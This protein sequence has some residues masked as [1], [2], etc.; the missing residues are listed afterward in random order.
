MP[1][2]QPAEGLSPS[3]DQSQEKPPNHQATPDLAAKRPVSERKV[4]TNRLNAQKSTGPRTLA[5]KLAIS[6]NAQRHGLLS[7]ALRFQDASEEREFQKL[8][9]DLKLEF[10]PIGRMELMLVEEIA[11]CHWKITVAEGW[12]Q[13]ELFLRRKAATPIL[14]LF[15]NSS[16]RAGN[17][18]SKQHDKVR[19]AARGGWDCRELVVKIGG[20]EHLRFPS[21]KENRVQFEAKLGNSTD[22]LLRYETTWKRDLYKAMSTLREMQRG[23]KAAGGGS[24]A[25]G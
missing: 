3:P 18:F 17:P 1:S 25:A 6:Q 11:V 22:S 2:Q 15:F 19:D 9:E 10:Q 7:K 16:D 8:L 5:G 4:R 20:N 21:D 24:T 13:E 14:D 23:R 12:A